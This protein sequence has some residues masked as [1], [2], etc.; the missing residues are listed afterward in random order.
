MMGWV[1]TGGWMWLLMASGT[2]AFWVLVA[3]TVRALVGGHW[4]PTRPTVDPLQVL[5]DRLARGEISPD[6]FEHRRR[7]LADGHAS[8]TVQDSP[9]PRRTP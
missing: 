3:L 9:P 4:A 5:R 8:P 6:D 7:L 2:V 1:G